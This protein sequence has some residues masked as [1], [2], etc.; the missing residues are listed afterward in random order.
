MVFMPPGSA[1]SMYGSKLFPAWFLAQRNGLKIIGASHTQ[2]YADKISRETQ[3]FIRSEAQTL[4]YSLLKE[5]VSNWTTTNDGEYKAAGVGGVIT[6]FRG[7]LAIIDDPVKGRDEAS[8]EVVR[9]KTWDWFTSD[10]RSRL[11]PNASIVLIQTRWHQD[12]LGGR[13][14]QLQE[15]RWRVVCLPATAVEGDPLGRLP[16]EFLWQ[17][18]AYGYGAELE[19]V[20]AEYE[21]SGAMRDWWSLYEQS[22][23]PNEGSLFKTGKIE[24]VDT[25]P[26]AAASVRAWDLAATA[27]VGTRDPDWTVGVRMSRSLSGGYVVED[28]VRLRGGPDEVEAAVLNTARLDGRSVPISFPQDPGQAGK[29]Q[30]LY[31]TRLLS[32][33]TFEA[34]P[35]TGDKSTRA[36][37][38]ASQVNAGNVSIVKA[39][40]NRRFLDEV[41]AF[42]SGSHDDQ[43]DA[44]SRAFG[45]VGMKRAP[46]RISA[47]ALARV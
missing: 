17:D 2:D 45:V 4:G 12:D 37:P 5:S 1:K 10:L 9:E 28:V 43:V 33:F 47:A 23:R 31:F 13:L 7:D 38:I 26:K 32:G 14:L 3:A 18:D 41:G 24:P 30:A 42:P 34:T 22:P 36:S 16:G 8:S 39:E 40:W 20:K 44:L 27:Q 35:E 15:G 19:K 6:G 25:A 11:K 29:T 46:M 21:Q